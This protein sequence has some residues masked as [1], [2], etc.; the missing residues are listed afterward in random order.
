MFGITRTTTRTVP[1]T[2]ADGIPNL[3]VHGAGRDDDTSPEVMFRPDRLIERLTE[4]ADG[5]WTYD[6]TVTGPYLCKGGRDHARANGFWTR[7]LR[8][9]GDLVDLG[10]IDIV[11]LAWG[12]ERLAA[13]VTPL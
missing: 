13:A 9:G 5:I 11:V 2:R 8:P 4:D 10:P 7:T 1:I 12:P 3:P 6:L